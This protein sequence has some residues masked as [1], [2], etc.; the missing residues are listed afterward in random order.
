MRVEG[1]VVLKRVR[2]SKG[3][4]P[5]RFLACLMLLERCHLGQILTLVRFYKQQVSICLLPYLLPPALDSLGS[6]FLQSKWL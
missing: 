1:V 4:V 6:R 3:S 5:V 2:E